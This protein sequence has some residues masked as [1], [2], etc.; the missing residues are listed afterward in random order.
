M[1]N[2]FG[3]ILED[4]YA[5]ITLSARSISTIIPDCPVEEVHRDELQ[6]TMH[7]VATGTP[8]TDHSFLMPQMVELRWGWS[9]S[10]AQAEGYVQAVYQELLTLQQS[11]QPFDVSTGKRQYSNMLLRSLQI[12]TDETSEFTLMGLAICQQVILD[13]GPDGG[14][15]NDFTEQRR[16]PATQL[17]A[18]GDFR[19]RTVRLVRRCQWKCLLPERDR[20]KRYCPIAGRIAFPGSHGGDVRPVSDG[21]FSVKNRSVIS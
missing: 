6:V 11:R 8:I 15:F 3:P 19:R 4:A 20:A 9:N 21:L 17:G 10:N 16:E 7:P 18:G 12:R 2:I 5:L 14:V 1:S 13:L